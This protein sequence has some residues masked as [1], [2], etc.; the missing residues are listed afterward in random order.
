MRASHLPS[1]PPRLQQASETLRSS[2]RIRPLDPPSKEE[3]ATNKVAQEAL[4]FLI[5]TG[6]VIEINKKLVISME[7]FNGAKESIKA[8]L[9]SQGSASTSEIR[10]ELGTSR[11]IAIPLLEMLDRDGITRREGLQRVLR[12]HSQ[13]R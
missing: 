11:R 1:L 5:Q 7:A 10:R 12:S 4:H 8:L 9:Q 13:D 2:L 3:L 6:V